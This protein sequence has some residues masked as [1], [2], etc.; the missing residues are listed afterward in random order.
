MDRFNTCIKEC[1]C[2]D[3][4]DVQQNDLDRI[5]DHLNGSLLHTAVQYGNNKAVF[6]LIHDGAKITEP[7]TDTN[8]YHPIHLAIK[9]RRYEIVT[10]LSSIEPSELEER[11]NTGNTCLLIACIQNDLK[12]VNLLLSLG[13]H[14]NVVNNALQTALHIAIENGNNEIVKELLNKPD[15]PYEYSNDS[16]ETPIHRAIELQ[17]LE[18]LQALLTRKWN[19]KRQNKRLLTYLDLAEIS[20]T[21]YDLV[22]E[23][24]YQQLRAKWK[25][26]VRTMGT[27]EQ[28]LRLLALEH[29]MQ[30]FTNL[31]AKSK[32]FNSYIESIILF[33]A[34]LG[35]IAFTAISTFQFDNFKST[36]FLSLVVA[37]VALLVALFVSIV[38]RALITSNFE[39][40]NDQFIILARRLLVVSVVFSYIGIGSFI[41]ATIFISFSISTDDTAPFIAAAIICGVALLAQLYLFIAFFSVIF[42]GY[43][44]PKLCG[45]CKNYN[46]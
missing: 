6:S 29:K 17:R 23:K 14:I 21:V 4:G 26:G 11:D 24:R 31:R 20:D 15:C 27:R 25:Q 37:G 12:M 32:S 2:G 33:S 13:A 40:K 45:L 30:K 9:F 44:S 5:P 36:I 46:Y 18:I 1:K 19:F 7:T 35:G 3:L 34:F 42:M 41:I 8:H 43:T 28:E 16:D 22:R 38:N 10:V 39:Y